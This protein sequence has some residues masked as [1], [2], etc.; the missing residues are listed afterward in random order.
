[1]SACFFIASDKRLEEV[2]NPHCKML[3]I[4]EALSLG[5][6]V[7]DFILNSSF[8]RDEPDFILHQDFEVKFDE[9]GSVDDGNADDNFSLYP[10]NEAEYYSKLKYGVEVQWVYATTGRAQ[11]IVDYIKAQLNEAESVELWNVWLTDYDKA[12]IK[13]S[14]ISIANLTANDI[15]EFEKSDLWCSENEDTPTYYRLIIKNK[16]M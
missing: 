3:S 2:K 4:N 1:M 6:E 9:D 14:T 5:V 7:A 15:I 12:E 10:F 16:G 13:S 8:D 11:K